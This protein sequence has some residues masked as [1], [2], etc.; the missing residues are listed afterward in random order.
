MSDQRRFSY[1]DAK[2]LAIDKDPEVRRTLAARTDIMPEILFFLAG[3]AS[4]EVRQ[5]IA[6][7]HATPRRA[8]LKLA[9][10]D[11][12]SVRSRLAEKIGR[13]IPELTPEEAENLGHLAYDALAILARDQVTVV[14][15]IVAEALRDVTHAPAGV[16]KRLA[17]DADIVVSGPILENSPVLSDNDLLE[18]LSE[19]PIKGALSAIAKRARMGHGVADAVARS[20]DV[21]AVG[22]LLSNP[23]AQIREDTLDWIIERAPTVE[24]W[25]VPLVRR[26]G[27]SGKAAARIAQ[28]VADSLLKNLMER[29]DMAPETVATLRNEVRQR[30]SKRQAKEAEKSEPS[31]V[32]TKTA[33]QAEA[34]GEDLPLWRR[35]L[36]EM[37][38]AL[39][40]AMALQQNDQLDALAILDALA[41][42]ED[43]FVT[44]ALSVRAEVPHGVAGCI[45]AMQSAK[46]IVSLA[47]K[48]KIP[49]G[50]LP[51]L[52][53]KLCRVPPNEILRST[54]SGEY[55]LTN[56]E[57]TWQLEFFYQLAMKA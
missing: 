40:A 38:G 35:I 2:R 10:D 48:A 52:Q 46:G 25:H 12:D 57:M 27:L 3:D 16:I 47:W 32:V 5:E 37:G 26:P 50:V 17:R 7:N 15:R 9:E 19:G 36:T 23:F 34:D 51:Q 6:A 33:V 31:K 44:A 1:D 30:L 22:I 55:P 14:R 11:D 13:I 29:E 24:S 42:G 21:E 45:V 53:I 39:E 4:P 18:I 41:Q 54:K 56:D 8:D 43:E 20:G 49:E 28:F